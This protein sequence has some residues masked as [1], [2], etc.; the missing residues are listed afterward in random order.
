MHVDR[1]S[2]HHQSSLAIDQ[3]VIFM[4]LRICNCRYAIAILEMHC[5]LK[6]EWRKNRPQPK[7]VFVYKNRNAQNHIR[8]GRERASARVKKECMSEPTN[9]LNLND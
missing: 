3:D 9:K 7:K 2:I 6:L 5:S 4:P 1:L 8:T